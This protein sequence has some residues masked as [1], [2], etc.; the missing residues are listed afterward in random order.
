MNKKLTLRLNEEVISRMKN[1]TNKHHIS[2][3]KFTES[4][5]KQILETSEE[6]SQDLTPIVQKYK[7]VLRNNKIDE[8]DDLTNFLTKKHT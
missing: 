8:I 5:F 1:Y 2:L 4:I 7:G 3:S 6:N